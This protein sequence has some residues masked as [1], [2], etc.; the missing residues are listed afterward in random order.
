MSA[1][2]W[3]TGG[4]AQWTAVRRLL[5]PGLRSGT[6]AGPAWRTALC[7]HCRIDSDTPGAKNAVVSASRFKYERELLVRGTAWI[8]G[9]DEAGRGP[10]AGP[11]VAAAVMF[12]AEWLQAGL[13]RALRGLNDSKQLTPEE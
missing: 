8:A 7:R 3:K 11:V 10:L 5:V 6:A 2:E 4:G 1:P 12:P 9:V 13:P